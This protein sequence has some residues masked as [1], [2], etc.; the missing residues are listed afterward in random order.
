VL[1]NTTER[2]EGVDAGVVRLIGAETEAI[3]REAGAE[4]AAQSLGRARPPAVSPY[5]DGAASIRIRDILLAEL[6]P[7]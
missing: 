4:L 3:V 5:G 1:R 6:S 7:R 2:P